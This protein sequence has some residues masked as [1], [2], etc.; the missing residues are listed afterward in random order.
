MIIT[1]GY[2]VACMTDVFEDIYFWIND[3]L[4]SL[5][6]KVKSV[7]TKAKRKTK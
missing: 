2:I 1:I 5:K 3:R 4:A 6:D 7:F